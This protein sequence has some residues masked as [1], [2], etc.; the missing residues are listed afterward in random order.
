MIG[1]VVLGLPEPLPYRRG[2]IQHEVP[3][4]S[5]KAGSLKVKAAERAGFSFKEGEAV[6][7]RDG[8]NGSLWRG[9]LMPGDVALRVADLLD[10]EGEGLLALQVRRAVAE[11]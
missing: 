6:W 2:V 8:G 9:W 4:T 1:I 3:L 10:C 7:L 11:A 5:C